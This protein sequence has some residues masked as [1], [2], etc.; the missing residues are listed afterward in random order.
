MIDYNI[1]KRGQQKTRQK[2]GSARL[3]F[4]CII[5]RRSRIGSISLLLNRPRGGIPQLLK[6]QPIQPGEM[7]S[8]A[9]DHHI[10]KGVSRDVDA[11]LQQTKAIQNLLRYGRGERIGSFDP[12]DEF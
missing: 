11:L 10:A 4:D 12:A 8:H 9:I 1:E 7:I 5:R 3:I 6:Q 2:P